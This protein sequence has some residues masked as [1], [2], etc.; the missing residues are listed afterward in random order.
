MG[1]W[2][3]NLDNVVKLTKEQLAEF[4]E[5]IRYIL[6]SIVYVPR[7]VA[8]SDSVAEPVA[9]RTSPWPLVFPSFGQLIISVSKTV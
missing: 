1:S 5:E 7:D 6:N 3:K 8:Y 4:G 2:S 9:L